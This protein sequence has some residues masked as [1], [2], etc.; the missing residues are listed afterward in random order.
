MSS[1]R[2]K[3]ILIA[4]IHD[5]DGSIGEL[6]LL[7]NNDYLN[8]LVRMDKNV[9]IGELYLWVNIRVN[10]PELPPRH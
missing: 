4:K 9:D 6:A 5:Y 2:L 7:L 10:N 8:Y 3:K 1:S